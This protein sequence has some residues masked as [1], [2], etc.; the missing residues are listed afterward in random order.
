LD[1]HINE[2]ELEKV[3]Y[4]A[5]KEKDRNASNISV[6]KPERK[7]PLGKSLK[8]SLSTGMAM[9]GIPEEASFEDSIMSSYSISRFDFLG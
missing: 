9:E 2:N 8:K 6:V 1:S 3:N 4:I 5:R 7:T